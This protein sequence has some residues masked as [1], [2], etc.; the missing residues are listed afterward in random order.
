MHKVS[1]QR[2]SKSSTMQFRPYGNVK[3]YQV[4]RGKKKKNPQ[5]HVKGNFK[6]MNIK[7]CGDHWSVLVLF[8]FL[9]KVVGTSRSLKYHETMSPRICGEKN[10]IDNHRKLI[11]QTANVNYSTPLFKFDTCDSLLKLNYYLFWKS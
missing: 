2:K 1:Q 11:S 7:Y 6:Q 3:T 5:N 8:K 10:S 4:R 9:W